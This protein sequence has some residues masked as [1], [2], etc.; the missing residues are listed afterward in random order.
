MIRRYYVTE[1]DQIRSMANPDKEFNFFISKNERVN[2]M[3][4]E[5]MNSMSHAQDSS[6][7]NVTH[8]SPYSLHP[9]DCP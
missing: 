5:A 1:N 2:E 8:T 7:H 3:Q 9:K 6:V 4:R